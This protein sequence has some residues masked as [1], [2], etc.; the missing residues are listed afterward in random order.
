M[1]VLVYEVRRLCGLRSTWFILGAVLLADAAVAAVLA[2]Q[3]PAGPLTAAAAV[4]SVTAVVPL[5]PL[6]IAALGAGA[7]GALSYGHEVRHPG[8]A[9]SRVSCP[10]RLALLA[11]KL[12]VTGLLAALLALGTVLVDALVLRLALAPGVRPGQ[13]FAL[14]VDAQAFASSALASAARPL[15]VFA[16]LVVLAGWAGLLTT[17]LVRSAAAGMLILCALPALLEP[18]L[19]LVLRLAGRGWPV[20]VRESL[21]FQYGLDQ[22]GGV[23]PQSAAALLDPVLLAAVLA[24]AGLLL[25]AGVLVQARRRA[26]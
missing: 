4:R 3:L 13:V 12:T 17:S 15:A 2:R 19:S 25:L 6:P 14:P 26:L 18:V 24:P 21:P 5:L 7:L 9:A 23:D 10:R 1:R 22:V 11:G 8:F 20:Q 16:V